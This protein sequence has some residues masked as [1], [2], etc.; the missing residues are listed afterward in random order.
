M[1][2]NPLHTYCHLFDETRAAL[3]FGTID[4]NEYID[5]VSWLPFV[6]VIRSLPLLNRIAGICIKCF[7]GAHA[8]CSKQYRQE[9]GRTERRAVMRDE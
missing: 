9:A 1:S 2:R 5:A 7:F 4:N 3:E 6:A 8:T